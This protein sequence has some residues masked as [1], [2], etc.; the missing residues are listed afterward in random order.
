MLNKIYSN[1]MYFP[2]KTINIKNNWNKII[3]KYSN[4]N[5]KIT[6]HNHE[7]ISKKK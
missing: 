6:I 3:H 1:I 7:K 2:Q 5:S 4:N